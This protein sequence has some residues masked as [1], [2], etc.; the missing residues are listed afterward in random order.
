MKW[1]NETFPTRVL[2]AFAGGGLAA[3]VLS[4]ALEG[5]VGCAHAI[6]LFLS[7]GLFL[8]NAQTLPEGRGKSE[9]FS[10]CVP[11]SAQV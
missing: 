2:V 1:L 8:F 9:L 10:N 5:L 3:V 6:K 4:K 11:R 7:A